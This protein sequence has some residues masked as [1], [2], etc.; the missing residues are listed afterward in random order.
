MEPELEIAARDL[1]ADALDRLPFTMTAIVPFLTAART[2][3]TSV[4]PVLTRLLFAVVSHTL[5]HLLLAAIPEPA[6]KDH[7][8]RH[9]HFPAIPRPARDPTAS[10]RRTA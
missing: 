7:R 10:S 1:G 2:E 8:S 4:A 3:F 5:D 6:W 9:R